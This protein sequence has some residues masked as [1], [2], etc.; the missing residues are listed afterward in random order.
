MAWGSNL[1][2]PNS[3]TAVSWSIVLN[4]M[5]SIDGWAEIAEGQAAKDILEQREGILHAYYQH[6]LVFGNYRVAVTLCIVGV[7]SAGQ[8]DLVGPAVSVNYSIFS[9]HS[10]QRCPIYLEQR[11]EN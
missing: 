8:Y 5:R 3:E 10:G 2:G 6:R 7:L 9:D 11:I 4:T 1:R